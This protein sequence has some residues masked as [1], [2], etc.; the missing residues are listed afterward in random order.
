M[1]EVPV[2]S[3]R[4]PARVWGIW[5]DAGASRKWS[6]APPMRVSECRSQ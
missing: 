6:A 4:E 3:V 5:K 1:I 2:G